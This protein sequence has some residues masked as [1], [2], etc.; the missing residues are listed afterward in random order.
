[1]RGF[2]ILDVTFGAAILGIVVMGTLQVF[3]FGQRQISTRVAERSAY[4]LARTRIEEV[5]AD[6]YDDALARVDS[7]LTVYGGLPAVRTTTVTFI[8]DPVDSLGASDPDGIEDYK[9]IEVQV[10]YGPD[11]NQKSV[12]LETIM[13]P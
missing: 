5:V 13:I 11:N 12:T 2:A 6:G 9:S 1:M 10:D 3:E 8:D 7:N 4:D